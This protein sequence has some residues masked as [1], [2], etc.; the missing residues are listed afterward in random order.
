[1]PLGFVKA[2]QVKDQTSITF[3]FITKRQPSSTL[4]MPRG[5]PAMMSWKS[6]FTNCRTSCG[7]RLEEGDKS[8]KAV[9]VEFLAY[10][11]GWS[12]VGPDYLG[13]LFGLS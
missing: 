6:S 12:V 9:H 4:I 10:F 13:I 5:R 1:L 7:I 2:A 11:A 8:L 3:L